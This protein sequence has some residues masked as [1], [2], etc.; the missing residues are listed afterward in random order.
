MCLALRKVTET[1]AKAV[2]VPDFK[3]VSILTRKDKK[4][5]EKL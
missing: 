3:E 5:K 4:S 2:T 1:D